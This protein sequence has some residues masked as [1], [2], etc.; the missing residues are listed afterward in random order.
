MNQ[1]FV[2]IDVSKNTNAI[3]IMKPD[4][5]KH[6]AFS[7]ANNLDG[8]KVLADRVAKALDDSGMQ[9]VKLGLESTS[10]Y[11]DNLA[12]YLRSDDSLAGYDRKVLD[13]VVNR[14]M[15]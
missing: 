12:R 14:F 7:V 9:C 1:L 6:S 2:G 15:L 8:A 3:H 13:C 10:V 5:S 4:G 11:G